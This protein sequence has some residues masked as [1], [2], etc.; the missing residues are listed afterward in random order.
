MLT[1]LSAAAAPSRHTIVSEDGQVALWCGDID[2]LWRMGKP[3]GEGGPW[4]DTLAQPGV[5]SDP[6]LMTGY[7]HKSVGLRHGSQQDVTFT[8]EVDFLHDG[9]WNTYQRNPGTSWSDRQARFPSGLFGALGPAASRPA[10]SVHGLVY[11]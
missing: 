9:T 8:I 5:P 7:D 4:K 6:Y 2:D 3:R 10:H 1:G 11:V